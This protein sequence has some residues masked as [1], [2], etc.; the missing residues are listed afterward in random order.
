MFSRKRVSS[1][2]LWGVICVI[3]SLCIFNATGTAYSQSV[4]NSGD[5][6]R[7][8]LI[9][10]APAGPVF[11]D[12]HLTVSR[13]PY[14]EWVAKFLVQEL[15]VDQSG[16]LDKNELD[17]LTENIKTLVNVK[18]SSHILKAMNA[19]ATDVAADDFIVWLRDRIPRAFDLIAQPQPADDA[20][21]L[22]SLLDI[23][24]DGA[25]STE[26][27]NLSSRT[28]RYRDLDND[29]T[30]SVAELLPYRDPRSQNAAVAPDVVS[31]PFF[32]VV[33][34]E[35]AERA[36]ERILQQYGRAE[37]VAENR[38]R[39]FE[40]IRAAAGTDDR[41]LSREEL[42]TIVED[43][44]F[45][46][47]MDVR[48]SVKANTSSIVVSVNQ[49]ASAFCLPAQ[50]QT[51]GEY[52][53]S[54]DGMPLKVI[55]LGGIANDRR[56]TQ[57]YLGQTF[58]MSDGDRNQYL[59]EGE[60]SGMLEALNRSSVR[61]SFASVD[62]DGDMMITR[63]EMFSFVKRDQLAAASHVEVSVKQDGKT[64]FGIL[65]RNSDRR[66]SR[67][68]LAAGSNALKPYDVNQDQRFADT[69]L[70]TEYILTISLGR[71]DFRRT[72]GQSE[73]MAMQTGAGDP[74]LPRVDSLSG[75]EW[76]RR[77][78][79]NQD[80][81]VS[82]REFLGTRQQF[83]KVDTDSDNLISTDEAL[84]IVGFASPG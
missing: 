2:S 27:L 48:L 51:F 74:V 78:D 83:L 75:P 68:E 65:D 1:S 45:H 39:Q 20:V 69:E 54:I 52:N 34:H 53:L 12:L 36:S 82:F 7:A 61:A 40:R 59:D 42:L 43:P 79:R 41:T 63:A 28:L 33:D 49:D 31:L 17:L 38:L 5:S 77:M 6:D 71:P 30:F 70:G 46:L 66:L 26:E 10:L 60:F 23:D 16:R 47:V 67:R 8:T 57:G 15:D 18:D 55:A 29:E 35:S 64:L 11:V 56:S 72:S 84:A 73:M 24:F 58:V 13:L 37:H 22:A 44:E 3:S 32:H 9:I 62:L 4:R 81:D 76:F 14:R 19:S 21:R 80:G 25:I 50:K